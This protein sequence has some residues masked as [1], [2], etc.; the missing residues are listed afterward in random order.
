M[1]GSMNLDLVVCLGCRTSTP[2]QLDLRTLQRS[3][4]IL[5][6]ECGL[7]YPIVDGVPIVLN[8]PSQYVQTEIA[9]FVERDLPTEVAAL[10][11]AAGD[12][13]AHL[14]EHLSTYL[15]AQWGDR[16]EPRP[17][18]PG[19]RSGLDGVIER[20]ADLPPVALAVELGCSVG[21]IVAELAVH[22]EHVVGIDLHFGTVRRARRILDGEPLEY[23]RRVIGR[24]YATATIDAAER[25]ARNRTLLCADAL[26]P[27][28]IP[29]SYDRVVALNL[30]DSVHN[31]RQLLSVMDGLCAPGGE[32]IVSSPYSWQSNVMT[33]DQRIGGSD[34]A[35]DLLTI[36]RDGLNLRARYLI[37]DQAELTWTLRRDS[38]SVATY[39]IHYIRARQTVTVTTGT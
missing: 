8:Q 26:D 14:L 32:L 22:A 2:D 35:A 24:H 7:R 33:D 38:R 16:A 5:T 9:T 36:L 34:P 6:C 1:I 18:G 19:A 17:D 25:A 37:E 15:D 27:P 12:P 4:D 10:L 29:Q 11:A 30:L 21:R 13:Y 39:R 23:N 3:G 28:L 20:L 31:P